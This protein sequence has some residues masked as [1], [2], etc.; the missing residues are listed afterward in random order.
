MQHDLPAPWRHDHAFGQDEIR[1][2]ERKTQIVIAIT[3]TMMIVEIVA[4]ALFG[5]M[6]LLA[7][8]LH[9]AVT[10]PSLTESWSV[11]RAPHWPSRCRSPST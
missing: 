1:S 5:S 11:R 2:G 10:T 4:G 8:G 6:A 7:D 3:A 9:L